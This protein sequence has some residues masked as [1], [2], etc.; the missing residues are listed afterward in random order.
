MQISYLFTS[1]FNYIASFFR[2]TDE[3][4][5]GLSVH[6]NMGEFNEILLKYQQEAEGLNAKTEEV[7]GII[8]K[9][10]YSRPRGGQRRR[11]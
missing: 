7:M 1:F 5:D 11:N 4:D 10:T 6:K 9:D 8:R 2:N 3:V